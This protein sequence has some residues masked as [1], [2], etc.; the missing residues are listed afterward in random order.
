MNHD[1]IESILCGVLPGPSQAAHG[2]ETL[3][4]AV[5]GMPSLEWAALRF[6]VLGDRSAVPELY[7][8]L[9]SEAASSPHKAVR[10]RAG[11]LVALVLA[12]EIGQ[13]IL[14]RAGLTHVLLNASRSLYYRRLYPAHHSL[15]ARIDSWARAG[16]G[17][18]AARLRG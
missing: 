3:G 6:R 7:A 14:A 2:V 5:A 9:W 11:A 1:I 4:L 18:I 17:R 8:P 16:M 12:E 10:A 15:R 13:P